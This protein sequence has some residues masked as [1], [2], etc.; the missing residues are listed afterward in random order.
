[1]IASS[2]VCDHSLPQR[3]AAVIG[4]NLRVQ[5]NFKTTGSQKRDGTFHQ[6]N[7]LKRSAA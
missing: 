5:E 6:I 3:N 1:M 7:V 2:G 4:W